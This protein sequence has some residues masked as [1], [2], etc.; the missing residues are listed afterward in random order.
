MT[1]T[2]AII[3]L[4]QREVEFWRPIIDTRAGALDCIR[5]VVNINKRTQMPRSITV[6]PEARQ[7][8]VALAGTMPA[9]S[10]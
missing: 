9:L 1:P 2:D 4:I 10:T 5:I 8:V 6:A 7:D 3:V